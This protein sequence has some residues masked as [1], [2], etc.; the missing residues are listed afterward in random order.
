LPVRTVHV[1]RPTVSGPDADTIAAERAQ[2]PDAEVH[3][4]R[5][6]GY[7]TGFPLQSGQEVTIAAPERETVS[8]G[9]TPSKKSRSPKA[10][11]P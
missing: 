9:R 4:R 1:D 3:N 7:A 6:I 2:L 11:L 5:L 10:S 8:G